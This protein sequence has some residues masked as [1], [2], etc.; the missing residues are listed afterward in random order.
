MPASVLAST[1]MAGIQYDGANLAT[2]T[3]AG[4]LPMSKRVAG[5]EGGKIKFVEMSCRK[6]S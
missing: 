3:T 2:T 6:S 4:D 5:V 1:S